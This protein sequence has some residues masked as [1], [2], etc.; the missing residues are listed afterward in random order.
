MESAK[1]ITN[2]KSFMNLLARIIILVMLLT[3]TAGC[4]SSKENLLTH[5]LNEPLSNVT[6]AK[7]EIKQDAGSLKIDSLTGGE[8]LLAGGSLQYTESQGLPSRSLT[9][10][11]EKATL[12]WTGN[13]AKVSGFRFPWDAC[14]TNAE[15][16]VHLNPNVAY[17]MNI[18]SAGGNINL[19]FDGLSVTS[20]MAET[21]GGN[22][23]VVLPGDAA[24]LSATAKTGGG[25]V[26][27]KIGSGAIGNNTVVAGTG[28]GKVI[29]RLPEKLAARI[30][31]TTGAGKA[32]VAAQFNQLDKTTYQSPGYETAVDKIQITVTSGAGDVTIETY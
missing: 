31:A 9:T 24:N 3:A 6:K 18:R 15:W 2:T 11:G 7:F 30:T 27:L 10:L 1:V 25:D 22:M 23:D 19:N 12:V 21:G 20:L 17:D 28:A 29:V 16:L 26:T 8:D 5:T 13:K 32:T 14:T 4:A